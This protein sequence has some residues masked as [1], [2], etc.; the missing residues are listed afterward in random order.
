MNETPKT[1]CLGYTWKGKFYPAS[2]HPWISNNHRKALVRKEK[3]R[4]K[5]KEWLP[6]PFYLDEPRE[7][8]VKK[9]DV[10]LAPIVDRQHEQ[11]WRRANKD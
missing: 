2:T 10:K 1:V 4:A 3:S 8:V 7:N 11:A 6:K 9:P 5:P